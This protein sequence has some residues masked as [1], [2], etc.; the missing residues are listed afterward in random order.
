MITFAVNHKMHFL[1]SGTTGTGKTVNITNQLN[2]NY[3]NEIYTNLSTAFS[4][5]TTANQIQAIIEAKVCV[6]RR[7]GYYG[8]E[9]GKQFIVIFIDDLNMPN[10]EIYGA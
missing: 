9:E 6:R 10:K 1:F 4:G 7:K 2:K 8:P 5:Q 3:Y